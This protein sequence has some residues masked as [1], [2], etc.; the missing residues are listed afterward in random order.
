MCEVIKTTKIRKANILNGISFSMDKGE[1]V[2]I[3]GPS[4][5]GKS[6]F[7]YVLSGMDRVDEGTITFLGQDISRKSEDENARMRLTEMGFVFQQMN[8]LPNL[9][10][11][12][13]I[14][15]PAL[16]CEKKKVRPER[17][18]EQQLKQK[19]ER[20]MEK[21]GIS[22]LSGRKTTE[23]S[24]GQLQRACICRALM[25]D[26][27]LLFADEPTG[28]LNRS[29]SDEVMDEFLRLNREGTSTMIV[30][31]DSKVAVRCDKVYYLIDGTIAGECE[32]GKYNTSDKVQRENKLQKWLEERG[33]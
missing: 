9:N 7:L 26:P 5:S 22:G 2:A 10:I 32:L 1:M 4:G 23:V 25:N 33:W 8:M 11:I 28:A 20:L 24:G 18:T 16:Q 19:A 29:A 6:T 14:I 17:R 15:L 12:D 27:K 31:H 3:M 30:T 13:N 21:V